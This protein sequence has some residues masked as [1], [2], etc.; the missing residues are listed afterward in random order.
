MVTTVAGGTRFANGR[1]WDG[2]GTAAI[3]DRPQG[4]CYSEATDSLLIAE[5][6]RIRRLYLATSDT[7]KGGL[8]QALSTSLVESGAMSVDALIAIILEFALENSTTL[9]RIAL[10]C[11]G[12]DRMLCCVTKIQMQ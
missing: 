5:G 4:M 1:N 7:R 12:V 8:K 11:F 6:S 3:F 2:I 10:T 9:H